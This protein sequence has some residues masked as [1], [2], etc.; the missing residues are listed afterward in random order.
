MRWSRRAYNVGARVLG[1]PRLPE[2]GGDFRYLYLCNTS[3]R[4]EHPAVL[5]ALLDRIYADYRRSG[6]HFFSLC[7]YDNDP[8]AA[9]LRGFMIRRLDF[10]LYVVTRGDAEPPVIPDGRP[11]FEMALA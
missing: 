9:A 10:H 2:P 5:R 11:G 3:I 7:V 8:L 6:Y 1:W 4:G